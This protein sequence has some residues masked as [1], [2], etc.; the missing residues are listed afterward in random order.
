MASI[1]WL[2][3]TGIA[4]GAVLKGG[5]SG[6]CDG[7]HTNL[8]S[9]SPHPLN[10]HLCDGRHTG[11]PSIFINASHRRRWSAAKSSNRRYEMWLVLTV[12]VLLV[13]PVSIGVLAF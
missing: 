5:W 8:D 10:L 12:A 4:N 2:P 1:G 6:Q 7:H 3:G 11:N 9:F 13:V